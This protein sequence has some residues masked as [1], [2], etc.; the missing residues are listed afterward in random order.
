MT[1]NTATDALRL[2]VS[3]AWELQESLAACRP[4]LP[5]SPPPA[6]WRGQRL[7]LMT[8]HRRELEEEALYRLLFGIRGAFAVR[9][10]VRVLFPVHPSPR[11]RRAA[12]ATLGDCPNVHLIEPL[13]LPHMGRL[14]SRAS[15]LLTDSGGLQEEA[16]FL[17]IPTL[18]LRQR[19][20]RPEGVA[21]GVLC[22]VGTDG[23]VVSASITALLDDEQALARMAH[24][25]P[26]F[27]DGFAAERMVA[28]WKA[29]E[30]G[31]SA[32]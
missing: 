13:P 1:G 17:G 18:V 8:V 12:V 32:S 4:L 5:G 14:L 26:V 7:V 11:V 29:S 22:C 28:A 3:G 15:L 21:A 31:P 9:R 2:C 27:G 6:L 23:D 30:W 20:E 19:T 25:S 24:P 16:V 10:D